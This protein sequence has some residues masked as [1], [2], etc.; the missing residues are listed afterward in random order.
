MAL[1]DQPFLPLYVQDFLTDEKLVECSAES[2]GVYI[3]LMCIMHKST[4]YGAILLKQKDRQ[5]DR[6][7]D[8]QTGRQNGRQISDF[9]AKLVK[10]LPFDEATIERALTELLE[11]GVLNIDGDMLYQKRMLN[12]GLLSEKRASAGKKG[13]STTNAK[14]FA[15]ANSSA[16]GSANCSANGSANTPANT[17]NEIENENEYVIKSKRED[18]GVEEGEKKPRRRKPSTL[19]K[20]QEARFNRFWAVYPRK[21]SIGDAEK[22]WAK[23][24][25]DEELS[26]TILSAVDT[27]KRY[28]SRFREISYTPHPATWLNA[29]S[30][31]NQYVGSE[32]PK[33][34]GASG[35][36]NSEPAWV[37]FKPSTGF[38]LGNSDP[39]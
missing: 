16:N 24:D 12:D 29:R 39:E 2:V 19:T 33:M 31:E 8:R 11:E 5:T 6:Q 14:D 3:M 30:W 15:A 7:N 36:T 26:A 25:P 9:A 20:K 28:D 38:K 23:I 13:A 1:R 10:H 22:A 27:A 37:A 35:G 17:E 34:G 21:V 18:K 32:G 4:K